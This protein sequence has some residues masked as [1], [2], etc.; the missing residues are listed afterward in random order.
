M[1]HIKDAFI[2][3]DKDN[4][5]YYNENYET[6][7]RQLDGLNQEFEETLS[8]VTNKDIIVAHK[9]FGYLCK[10]YGL[11]QIAIEG[12]MPDSEPILREWKK[13]FSWRK[14][15]KSIP[16]SLKTGKPKSSQ[17]NCERNWCENRGFKSTGGIER[18]TD[19]C[20]RRLFFCY[21]DKFKAD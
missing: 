6:Y 9:A 1:E 13:L 8:Q 14:K 21:E 15:R 3:A 16:F 10:A 4:A 11:N 20:R 17:Y 7:S 5:E 19:G 2:E 18:R 12:L